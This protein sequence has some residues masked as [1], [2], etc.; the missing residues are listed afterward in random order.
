M[1][2]FCG[3]DTPRAISEPQTF[4]D[5]T[6]VVMGDDS[7]R[8]QAVF[9]THDLR[10]LGHPKPLAKGSE[11]HLRALEATGEVDQELAKRNSPWT[12]VAF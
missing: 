11:R 4:V 8:L 12:P 6:T 10:V 7:G 9:P 5:L 3:V 1:A 2:I